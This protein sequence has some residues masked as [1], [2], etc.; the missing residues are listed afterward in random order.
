MCSRSARAIFS[1]AIVSPTRATISLN[2]LVTTVISSLPSTGTPAPGLGMLATLSIL[3]LMLPRRDPSRVPTYTDTLIETNSN[4]A[5]ELK[6]IKLKILISP[7]RCE[8]DLW[9]SVPDFSTVVMS[10]LMRSGRVSSIQSHSSSL[11]T[12]KRSGSTRSRTTAVGSESRT[13]R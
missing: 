11:P 5:S 10:E 12:P 8:R 7:L 6:M 1:L 9:Y 3:S 4:S 2:A 13:L